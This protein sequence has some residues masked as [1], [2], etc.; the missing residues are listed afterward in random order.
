MSEVTLRIATADDIPTLERW[1]L[2]PTVIAATTD[3][4]DTSAAF[5]DENDWNENIAMHQDDVWEHWIAE[6]DG[7]PIGA[8]MMCDPYRE[9]TH[10]WGDVEP[11][12]R[13]LD[14]WIGEAAD[15]GKGFGEAMMRLGVARCFANPQVTAILID[16][17]NSNPR[18]HRFYQRVGFVPVG[19]QVF[20]GEDDCL[21]HRLSRED[22]GRGKQ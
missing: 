15:R 18:A 2:D 1:D 3:N 7:R 13:A 19:R 16:P 21:V 4:P 8:M 12:L 6:V 20:N 22:W 14:I 17:L 10:Y 11:N 5:G 9:P